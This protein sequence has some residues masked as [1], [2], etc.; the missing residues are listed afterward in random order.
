MKV[1]F[2]VGEIFAILN[3]LWMFS[4]QSINMFSE[5]NE[6]RIPVWFLFGVGTALPVPK[7]VRFIFSM[8]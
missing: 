2:V 8:I 7:K 4:P 5:S 3:C 1:C 6:S